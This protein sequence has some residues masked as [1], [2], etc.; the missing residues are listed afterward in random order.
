MNIVDNAAESRYEAEVPGGI[1]F[2]D[3]RLKPGRI[4]FTHTEVPEA[5]AGHGVGDALVRHV[6]DDARAR[7][8]AVVPMCPFVAAWIERHPEYR[9]LVRAS[10]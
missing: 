10:T 9:E 2:V 4:V 3:Y 6:L 1:A 8:L 5:A 7:G